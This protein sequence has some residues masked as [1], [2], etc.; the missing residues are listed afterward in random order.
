MLAAERETKPVL[1][2]HDSI[3]AILEEV[4]DRLMRALN[5]DQSGNAITVLEAQIYILA[6]VLERA[7]IPDQHREATVDRLTSVQGQLS[8]MGRAHLV[9]R[10]ENTLQSVKNRANSWRIPGGTVRS[11]DDLVSNRC[12]DCGHPMPDEGGPPAVCGNC[13][14]MYV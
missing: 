4:S 11:I 12:I 3:P 2:A 5:H 13:H 6:E 9:R 8:A 10:M 14:T 1:P 7:A